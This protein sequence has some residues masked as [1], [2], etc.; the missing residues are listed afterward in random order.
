[1]NTIA[2]YQDL[3]QYLLLLKLLL[4]VSPFA[5]LYVVVV[6]ATFALA[7]YVNPAYIFLALLFALNGMLVEG[8]LGG[9]LLTFKR[10]IPALLLY[11]DATPYVGNPS[12]GPLID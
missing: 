5:K 8:V 9:L 3:I 1:M 10:Y 11:L 7:P 4:R 2:S 12:P 6:V